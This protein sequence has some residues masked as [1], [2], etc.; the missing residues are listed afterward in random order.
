MNP[1]LPLDEHIYTLTA[2]RVLN[3]DGFQI[4][5]GKLLFRATLKVRLGACLSL[6]TATWHS[7]TLL[8]LFFVI[9][10]CQSKLTFKVLTATWG[11][12][13]SHILTNLIINALLDANANRK[14]GKSPSIQQWTVEDSQN[15]LFA[16][17]LRRWSVYRYGF[18]ICRPQKC[19]VE[20]HLEWT[21]YFEEI[22]RWCTQTSIEF[23]W[24]SKPSVDQ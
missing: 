17:R 23:Y 9:K 16:N 5:L 19:R 4:N 15:C 14:L 12:L 8:K 13:P 1:K 11:A 3:T 24:T 22:S 7:S 20:Y 6:L 10:I 18:Q 21:V 2:G